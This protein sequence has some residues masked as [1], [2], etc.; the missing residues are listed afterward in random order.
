MEVAAGSGE[1]EAGE[2]SRAAPE[3]EQVAR[4]QRDG[5]E[6]CAAKGLHLDAGVLLHAPDHGDGHICRVPLAHRLGLA[7]I[8]VVRL[9]AARRLEV[10]LVHGGTAE[11]VASRG[12]PRSVTQQ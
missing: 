10:V 5:L 11:A 1:K 6:L 7:R 12:T 2:P 3:D 4:L 9:V 8:G